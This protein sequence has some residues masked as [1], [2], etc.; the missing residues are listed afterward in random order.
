MYDSNASFTPTEAR[1]N[2]IL[3][4]ADLYESDPI[5]RSMVDNTVYLSV[6]EKVKSQLVVDNRFG[7]RH[8]E[9]RALRGEL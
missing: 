4:N 9:F 2:Q 8:G 5:F 6:E 7:T 1:A 3:R